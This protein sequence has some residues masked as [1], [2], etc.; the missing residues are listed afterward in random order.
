M[1][2]QQLFV[3]ISCLSLACLLHNIVYSEEIWKWWG[4]ERK[5]QK[6]FFVANC[7][8][9]FS[10][11]L[12]LLVLKVWSVIIFWGLLITLKF[13]TSLYTVYK[14]INS[15]MHLWRHLDRHGGRS[16]EGPQI[17]LD[18]L[19]EYS[20][21]FPSWL[22]SGSVDIYPILGFDDHQILNSNQNSTLDNDVQFPTKMSH[23]QCLPDVTLTSGASW[24]IIL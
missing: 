17:M 4:R 1:F 2:S 19:Y 8:G 13:T 6:N 24:V 10:F 22:F 14:Y 20:W 11:Y 9:I 21:I 18:V 12:T 23:I 16:S 3:K 5:S 15:S 7:W